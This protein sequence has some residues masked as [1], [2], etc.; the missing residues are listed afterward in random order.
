MIWAEVQAAYGARSRERM[1]ALSAWLETLDER[2]AEVSAGVPDRW[3]RSRVPLLSLSE[4][5]ER[6]RALATSRRA[7][8]RRLTELE[9][10]PAWGFERAAAGIRRRLRKAAVRRL[11]DELAQVRAALQTVEVF[12]ASI[13]PPRP[14]RQR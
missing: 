9:R 13:G 3:E 11:E 10:E 6:L 8:G 5:H 2:A 14:T 4:R 7:L 1:L 12:F